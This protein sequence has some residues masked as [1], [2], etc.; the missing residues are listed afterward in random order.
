[1]FIKTEQNYEG[2]KSFSAVSNSVMYELGNWI[3]F[4]ALF[5]VF[6]NTSNRKHQ[7]FR[8]NNKQVNHI[9]DICF[10]LFVNF[11]Q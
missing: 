2:K 1:M 9:I 7:Q 11:E 3:I 6:T 5:V 10:P 4:R 8:W